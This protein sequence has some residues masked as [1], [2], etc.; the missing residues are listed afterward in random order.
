MDRWTLRDVPVTLKKSRMRHQEDEQE[1][2]IMQARREQDVKA[3]EAADV[4]ELRWPWTSLKWKIRTSTY[5]DLYEKELR[6]YCQHLVTSESSPVPNFDKA[7]LRMTFKVAAAAARAVG[8][9]HPEVPQE[10][11]RLILL[12]Q[13]WQMRRASESRRTWSPRT[14]ATNQETKVRGQS[15]IVSLSVRD[16]RSASAARLRHGISHFRQSRNVME[17]RGSV[18]SASYCGYNL[19]ISTT[20]SGTWSG[21]DSDEK[22]PSSRGVRSSSF[23]S[24]SSW[25]SWRSCAHSRRAAFRWD[26]SCTFCR[27]EE[28][29]SS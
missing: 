3:A 17:G 8:T 28:N 2:L 5:D 18:R 9:T 16:V 15:Q 20:S 13:T 23:R 24:T 4:L 7:S 27:A 22:C 21:S 12:S 25:R 14:W 10:V 6:H 29:S 19:S 26:Q 11:T 1:K